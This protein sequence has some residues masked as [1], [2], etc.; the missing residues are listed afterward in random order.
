MPYHQLD[1]TRPLDWQGGV[2][3][4]VN[5]ATAEY[6]RHSQQEQLRVR[7]APGVRGRELT[8]LAAWLYPECP[9]GMRCRCGRLSVTRSTPN[10]C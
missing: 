8:E 10:D 2:E 9:A 4:Q 3:P 6:V 5:G 7:Q 1:A